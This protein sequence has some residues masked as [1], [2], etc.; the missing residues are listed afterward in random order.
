[1][2]S[3][4]KKTTLV[5][6]TAIVNNLLLTI[7]ALIYNR[8]IIINYGSSIAGLI[9]TMTQFTSMF[10]VI[11]GGFSLS[12]VV[13]IY[14]PM[15]NSDY[16][17]LN[18]ILYTAKKYF[19]KTTII[20]L[21]VVLISGT[22]YISFIDSPLLFIHTLMLL[23][24]TTLTTA[25]TIGGSNIYSVVLSGDNKQYVVT[26]ISAICKIITWS[27]SIVLIVYK[28]NIILVYSMNVITIVLD[29]FALKYFEKKKYPLVTFKGEYSIKKIKGIKDMIFQKIAATVFTSTD[30]V[31][32]SLGL[33]LSKANVYYIYNQIFSGVFQYL[34]SLSGAPMDTFGHLLSSGELDSASEKF[35]IYKKTVLLL[36]TIFFTVA[37]VMITPFLIIYTRNVKDENYI[38][39]GLAIIFFTYNFF[40]I[41]NMPYGMIINVSGQFKKQN[42][43]TGIA[44]V[45]NIVLSII[46]M[47]SIG[48]NGI[49]LG[50]AVG[51]IIIIFANIFR[52]KE[53]I[54]FNI[55]K[56]IAF[57]LF[58]YAVGL[59][60]TCFCSNYFVAGISNYWVWA[61]R[62]IV[63]LLILS[64][65][66][67]VINYVL[68]RNGLNKSL[69]YYGQKIKVLFNGR[70]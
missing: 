68:D 11:E 6:I 21:S 64:F 43:Q 62:A 14:K 5:A 42:V 37:A 59:I 17:E 60:V 7:F 63:V 13:A 24:L 38:V 61:I 36:S 47:K 12:V 48:L 16:S 34:S 70:K 41:N 45:T 10:T 44:A 20:Y 46:F 26:I 56:D 69:K 31:L 30:L 50:S 39:P 55:L 4:F 8:L 66:V 35:L 2:Q 67:V 3:G 29:I 25:L 23:I 19:H 18:D 49:I 58:N 53:I 40:K 22:I 15:I 54:N 33:S 65:V 28:V 1:M 57:L 32:V 52:A 51:T 27:V 9:S